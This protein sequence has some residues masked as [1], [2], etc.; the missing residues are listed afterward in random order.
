M[1]V[2]ENN[3]KPEWPKQ[4]IC[5]NRKCKSFL[6]YE[7]VDIK[8]EKKEK[9]DQRQGNYIDIVKSITCPCCNNKIILE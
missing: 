8:A 6:E 9:Y 7:E 4:I 1:R 5:D 3:Y 2:I